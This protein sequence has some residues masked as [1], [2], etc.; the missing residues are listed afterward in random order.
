MSAVTIAFATLYYDTASNIQAL[1]ANKGD[2]GFEIDTQDE[3]TNIDGGTT[4]VMT[5]ASTGG[6][7]H[8]FASVKEWEAI[9]D[10]DIT[11]SINGGVAMAIYCESAGDVV[12]LSNSLT[13]NKATPVLQQGFNPWEVTAVFAAGTVL[14]GNCWAVA[15]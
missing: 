5:R 13:T 8:V 1:S 12:Q 11:I 4:W 7:A 6:A 15:W 10:A 9:T 2:F 14:V 3:Y